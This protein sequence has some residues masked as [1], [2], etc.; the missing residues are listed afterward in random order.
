M[1]EVKHWQVVKDAR[2]A[3]EAQLSFYN[4]MLARYKAEKIH[5]QMLP[6]YRAYDKNHRC[7]LCELSI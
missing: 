3:A 7:E 1:L 5:A 6:L 4:E 2:A